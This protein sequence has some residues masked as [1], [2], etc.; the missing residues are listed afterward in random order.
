MRPS[1]RRKGYFKAKKVAEIW[2]AGFAKPQEEKLKERDRYIQFL[3][4][5]RCSCSCS[6]CCNPRSSNSW[7]SG[8]EKLTLQEL[9]NLDRYNEGLKEYYEFGA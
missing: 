8:K 9:R 3:F 5:N 1:R 4:P 6:G 2:V 7:V